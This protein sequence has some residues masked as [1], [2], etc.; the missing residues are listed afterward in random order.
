[1]NS[2]PKYEQSDLF[3]IEVVHCKRD[4]DS[5]YIGRGSILGN[6][7]RMYTEDERDK[8]CDSY[9]VYFQKKIDEQDPEFIDELARLTE[10]A[11]INGYVRL[12]CFCAP[13]RCHGDT[14][15]RFLNSVLNS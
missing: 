6:P 15:A 9:E 8:V 5:I 11:Y 3:I 4:P 13:R 1:M 7:D 12:G 14:V 10:S 2:N